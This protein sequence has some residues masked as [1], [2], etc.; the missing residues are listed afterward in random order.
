MAGNKMRVNRADDRDVINGISARPY[1]RLKT[2]IAFKGWRT[3][4]LSIPSIADKSG[5]AC[6]QHIDGD[7]RDDLIA[8]LADRRKAMDQR[9]ANGCDNACA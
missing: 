8:A 4:P 6:R 1:K 3:A 9:K 2:C 5:E 7:A